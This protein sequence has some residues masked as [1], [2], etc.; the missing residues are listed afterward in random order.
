MKNQNNYKRMSHAFVLDNREKKKR[1]GNWN[2][3]SFSIIY[4]MFC[5]QIFMCCN[6]LMFN[7]YHTKIDFVTYHTIIVS[8]SHE[9]SWFA[10]L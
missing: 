2:K 3:I 4:C 7:S 1:K 10:L 9:F 8:E 6:P 5:C